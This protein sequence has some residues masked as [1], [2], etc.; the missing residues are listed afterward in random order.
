MSKHIPGP[1]HV[2]L[3]QLGGPL[4][5]SNEVAA[6]NCRA[7]LAQLTIDG[8]VNV[9]A[10]IHEMNTRSRVAYGHKLKP[11]QIKMLRKIAAAYEAEAR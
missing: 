8:R 9:N 7:I 3:N 5:T 1:W 6:A 2:G 4:M 11:D 10:F